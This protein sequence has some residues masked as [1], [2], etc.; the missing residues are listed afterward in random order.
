MGE[1]FCDGEEDYETE[2]SSSNFARRCCMVALLLWLFV[3][4]T[5]TIVLIFTPASTDLLVFVE[6]IETK[7]GV[8]DVI[9]SELQPSDSVQ[10]MVVN[11]T[12][13]E[14]ADVDLED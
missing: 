12:H 11:L 4:A 3:A 1:P 10:F 2:D 6:Q 13:I 14:E 9:V 5:F 7:F 8:E